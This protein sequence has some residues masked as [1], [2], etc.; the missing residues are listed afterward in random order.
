MISRSTLA[1]CGAVLILAF[2][3]SGCGG[4]HLPHLPSLRGGGAKKYQGTGARIPVLPTDQKLQPA[5]ALKGVDFALPEPAAQADW[6]LPGGTPEQSVE[7]VTAGHDFEIAWRRKI[8][9]GRSRG[10]Y[11]TATPVVAEGRI[12]TL[13]AAGLVSA[14]DAQTGAEVWRNNLAPRN[15]RD[16]DAYGGGVAYAGGVLYMASGY[17]F[18]TALDAKTGAVK[19]RTAVPSPIHGAPTVVDGR[20]FVVDVDDQ[21]Y[22]INAVDGSI[23]WN[24]QAL[25]EPARVIAASSPAVSG[26]VVVA[27]FASGEVTA[28]RAVNGT[29][30]WTDT[31]SFTNRNNALSEIRD[32][33]GRP[34]VYRGDVL[35]GSHSGVFGAISL[36]E[37]GRRWDL[38]ISTITTP[39]PDGDV[40]Y[41]VDQSGQLICI[42]RESGQVFW[43]TNLN[44]DVKKAKNRAEWS[45]PMLASNRLIVVSD[46][47][48]ARALNPKTGE[49]LK[50]LKVSKG[51]G[52][53]SPIA[54][55]ALVYVMTDDGELVAIR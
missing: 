4:I 15:G 8:G 3:V 18:I 7:H 12:F 53:L 17:R 40:V 49:R 41:V 33:P 43:T 6:P 9:E 32:V 48:E 23:L 34:V 13:D 22:A 24:Y 16:R 37:G 55:G 29:E 5:A 39:L 31:L 2:A 35:A 42:A 38:P 27:P 44:A 26:E 1:R 20:L 47:G 19:W 14:H 50:S 30:L 10:H 36:R 45:G 54:A 51:G 52:I 21:L 25:E 28:F 46:K 11:I